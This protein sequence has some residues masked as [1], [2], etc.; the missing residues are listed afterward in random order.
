MYRATTTEWGAYPFTIAH[1]FM[2]AAIAARVAQLKGLD[3][4]G[5]FETNVRPDVLQNGPIFIFSTHAERAIQTYNPPPNGASDETHAREF[6]YFLG[7]GDPNLRWD[8]TVLDPSQ[9]GMMTGDLR[10]VAR[11]S[12][13]WLRDRAHE[14]K[15]AGITDFWGLD[16]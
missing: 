15:A 3:V 2:L 5:S 10:V 4:G 8:I 1:A 13:E 9:I 14:F 11:N 6:G 7:S 12:A 16:R